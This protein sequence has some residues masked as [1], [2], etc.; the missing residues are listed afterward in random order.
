[1]AKGKG[2]GP[3][4]KDGKARVSRNAVKHAIYYFDPVLIEGKETREEWEAF[5]DG[6]VQSLAPVGTLEEEL[7]ESVALTRWR[8]RRVARFETAAINF[9]VQETADRLTVADMYLASDKEAVEDPEPMRVQ[10]HQE[11]ALIP[12]E[13]D[14]NHITRY[15][16]HLHRLFLQTLHELEALQA[17][18]RGE[19]TNL[20]RI[21]VVAPPRGAASPSQPKLPA[22]LE[23]PLAILKEHG[24]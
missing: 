10:G 1:M 5:R 15:E 3:R 6:I 8:M 18:R 7:A 21:D 2:G 4:T 13:A 12:L 22:E 9:R 23:R 16:A 20:A 17:R 11:K 14:L 19:K 24:G